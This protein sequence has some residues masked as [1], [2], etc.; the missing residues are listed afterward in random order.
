MSCTGLHPAGQAFA[1]YLSQVGRRTFLS[2]SPFFPSELSYNNGLL[3]CL[4]SPNSSMKTGRP[5]KKRLSG[6]GPKIVNR[7][8]ASD[9]PD[10]TYRWG[11]P[12]KEGWV[13]GWVCRTWAK[14]NVAHMDLSG[15]TGAK[16]GRSPADARIPREPTIIQPNKSTRN[17]ESQREEATQNGVA[18][19]LRKRDS[20]CL[21]CSIR[22]LGRLSARRVQTKELKS[23]NPDQHYNSAIDAFMKILNTEGPA[24]LYAG[25]GAGLFGT[26]ASAFS[27]FYFYSYV[28]GAYQKR[29]SPDISTGMELILG[30]VAGALSQVT[31]LPVSV[32]TTRQQTATK[33]EKLT[34]IGTMQRIIREEG[35]GGLWRGLQASLVLCV[36]PAITYGSFEKMKNSYLER[37]GNPNGRLTAGQTF[38][39]GALSKALATI[40]TYPYIMAKVKMQWKPPKHVQNLSEKEREAVTY[41]S[42]IDILQKVL[43]REG[44][45]GW[46]NGLQPQIIKAVLC[47]AILFVSKD[48]FTIWTILLFRFLTKAKGLG[49][50]LDATA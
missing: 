21:G 40:V 3:T 41:K 48:Q 4:I 50:K 2:S 37:S 14:T 38:I 11:K 30:A 22:K 9:S 19:T 10:L 20:G 5:V 29:V 28:R 49:P 26:V 24:G 33:E 47:Q 31:T 36:N 43:V 45:A 15:R 13:L 44:L 18:H 8:T 39:I 17:S 27:Y 35:P 6:E 1:L 7:S 32:V 42:S 12:A 46:Y 25:L 34:F 16:G 23:L